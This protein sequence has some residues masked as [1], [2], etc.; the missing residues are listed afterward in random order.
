MA[1]KFFAISLAWGLS[2][3]VFC[4]THPKGES[5]SSG[6]ADAWTLWGLSMLVFTLIMG[7]SG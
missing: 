2:A 6:E 3:M 5:F 7:L 1:L 4:W